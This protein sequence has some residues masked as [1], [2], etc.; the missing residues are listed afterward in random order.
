MAQREAGPA[1]TRA[2]T[3][4]NVRKPQS[5]SAEALLRPAPP[6]LSCELR[7]APPT[8]LGGGRC[9]RRS[10]ARCAC[11]LGWGRG[12]A[13]AS[14]ARELR[15]PSRPTV[16]AGPP[17]R[18]LSLVRRYAGTSGASAGAK[19]KLLQP[20]SPRG[21]GKGVARRASEEGETWALERE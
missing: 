18:L 15:S 4:P 7:R 12:A 6:H 2:A 8:S 20:R 17:R 19:S 10:E 21:T 1:Q 5:A 16:V 14:P 3:P 9:R 13:A 11:A